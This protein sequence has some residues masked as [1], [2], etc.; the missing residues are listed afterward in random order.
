M[1]QFPDSQAPTEGSMRNPCKILN[2]FLSSQRE[3]SGPTCPV[4]MWARCGACNLR[5]F[6]LNPSARPGRIQQNSLAPV[7]GELGW[8]C[9]RVRADSDMVFKETFLR[10][11][12]RKAENICGGDIDHVWLNTHSPSTSQIA[13]RQR[14]IMG[15][16]ELRGCSGDG[17]P[18]ARRTLLAAPPNSPI[19]RIPNVLSAAS[20]RLG[21]KKQLH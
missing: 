12:T 17:W 20:L 14:Q 2:Y 8:F 7:P 15:T 11:I 5:T 1:K 18:G 10:L 6:G 19:Y 13:S 9:R 3:M 4:G 21:E 16:E